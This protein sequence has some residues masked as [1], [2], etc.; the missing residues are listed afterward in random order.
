LGTVRRDACDMSLSRTRTIFECG[1]HGDE[2]GIKRVAVVVDTRR[3]D[4][5]HPRST[6]RVYA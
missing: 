6:F 2:C 3:V 1:D 4:I 5:Q